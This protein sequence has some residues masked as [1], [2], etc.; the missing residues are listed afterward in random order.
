MMGN[1]RFK[2]DPTPKSYW[3]SYWKSLF[4]TFR[5]WMNTSPPAE[6]PQGSKNKPWPDTKQEGYTWGKWRNI[7]A[8]E[9]GTHYEM[10]AT[11]GNDATRM[12]MLS[13][14]KLKRLSRKGL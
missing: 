14:Q 8:S 9:T 10:P 2:G 3:A 6:Q 13:Q 4:F 1:A 12:E 5:D 11:S 7:I